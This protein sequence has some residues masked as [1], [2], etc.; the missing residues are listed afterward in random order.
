[1]KSFIGLL[2]FAA[3]LSVGMTLTYAAEPVAAPGSN[4]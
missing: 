1:M 2:A 4:T 3:I